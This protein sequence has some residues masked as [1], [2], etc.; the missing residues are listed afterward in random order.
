MSVRHSAQTILSKIDSGQ[1]WNKRERVYND[2]RLCVKY[3]L[4][5]A[6]ILQI[7]TACGYRPLAYVV[8]YAKC[9]YTLILVILL[10]SKCFH[11]A[12]MRNT[13]H[14]ASDGAH[15]A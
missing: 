10:K 1:H 4:T 15:P 7:I 11:A 13:M 9:D 8:M 6:Y 14:A 3:T 12:I 2:I 5:A